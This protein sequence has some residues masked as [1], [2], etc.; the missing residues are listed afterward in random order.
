M[1]GGKCTWE[2]CE[3]EGTRLAPWGASWI[4]VCDEH[5]EVAIKM[6]EE[7]ERKIKEMK[8]KQERAKEKARKLLSFKLNE[9]PFIVKEYDGRPETY[10]TLGKKI[11]Y[12]VYKALIEAKAMAKER[13]DEDGNVYYVIKDEQKAAQILEKHGFK[14]ILSRE[15]QERH[16]KACEILRQAGVPLSSVNFV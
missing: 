9:V 3:K 15:W 8:E 2:G 13:D 1:A 4:W 11:P 5:A 14:V 10:V 16:K 7:E 12:E 6:A